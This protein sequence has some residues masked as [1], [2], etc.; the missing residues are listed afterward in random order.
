MI[1]GHEALLD[2]FYS[3]S[4]PSYG[5]G[6]FTIDI[7]DAIDD[8]N[9]PSRSST[10]DKNTTTTNNNNEEKEA[11]K[12][13][14]KCPNPTRCSYHH[15]IQLAVEKYN[16]K[17]EIVRIYHTKE[18]QRLRAYHILKPGGKYM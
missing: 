17:S 5:K 11:K 16:L 6:Y 13:K 18:I 8:D 9:L 1:A 2:T 4:V 12:K 3:L 10:E 7:C 15:F 14:K